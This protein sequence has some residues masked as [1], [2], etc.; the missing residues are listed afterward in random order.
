MRNEPILIVN[1]A[2][3]NKLRYHINQFIFDNGFAPTVPELAG[4]TQKNRAIIESSLRA[5]ADHNALVLHPNTFDI[6][7]AHPFALFPTLFWVRAGDKKWWGNCTWCSLGIATLTNT[8]TDIYTKLE[9]TEEPIIIQVKDGKVMDEN[10]VVHFPLPAKRTWDNVI[11]FCANTL[12]F[13]G[14]RDVYHWCDQHRVT[15]GQV[16]PINQVWELA[17]LWYGYYLDPDWQRKTPEFAERIFTRVGLTS[18]FWK[19]S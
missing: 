1:E 4:I 11:H 18:A 3:Q 12:T 16:L 6:W 8:D 7:V 2:F 10:Y 9:G 5:L 17:K 15:K 14:E 19:L 13:R